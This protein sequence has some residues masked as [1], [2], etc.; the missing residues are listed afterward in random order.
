MTGT[1]S[2]SRTFLLRTC[3]HVVEAVVQGKICNLILAYIVSNT[4]L[5]SYTCKLPLCIYQLGLGKCRMC[6]CL[7]MYMNFIMSYDLSV[8]VVEDILLLH[9]K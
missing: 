8:G 5:L 7:D 2:V 1:A 3:W 9:G 4:N 6:L